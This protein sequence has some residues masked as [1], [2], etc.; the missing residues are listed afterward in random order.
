MLF[1]ITYVIKTVLLFANKKSLDSYAKATKV[2]EMIISFAFLVSG[3]WLFAIIGGI[4]YFQI[5][6]LACVFISIPLAVI[7]FKRHKKGLALAS[8]FLIIMAYGL[9]EMSRSLPYI[10]AKATAGQSNTNSLVA[11]GAVV[12]QANCAF[13]HGTDGKKKYRDATDLTISGY[14]EDNITKIVLEGSKGKMP[15]YKLKISDAQIAAVSAF[16]RGMRPPDAM[17]EHA[18]TLIQQ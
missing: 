7:G 14:T 12:Y 8:L 15:A 5:I 4:K 18:D 6:K 1:L 17:L 10:P 16:V 2:P 9:S 11:E 13:C 3:I